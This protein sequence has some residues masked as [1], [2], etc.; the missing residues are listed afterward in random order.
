[1]QK[2]R[3]FLPRLISAAI[4]IVMEI[5]ALQMLSRNAELQRLWLARA[6]HGVGD[7]DDPVRPFRL[8]DQLQQRR[9]QMLAV[10]DDLRAQIKDTSNLPDA[11]MWTGLREPG[12]T[13]LPL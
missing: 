2:E 12:M 3:K 4:F 13:T 6:A 9:G 1:M 10:R 7:K 8:V 11:V 5:A